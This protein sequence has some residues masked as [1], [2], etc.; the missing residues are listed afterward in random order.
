MSLLLVAQNRNMEPWKKAFLKEENDLDIEIWPDVQNPDQVQFAVAWRH[1]P[2][3]LTRFP[4]L[5]AVSSLGAGI[6]HILDDETL[7]KGLKIC[8]VVDPNL[9]DD[10]KEYMLGAVLNYRL[11]SYTYYQQ[12]WNGEWHPLPKKKANDFTIGIMGLGAIGLPVAKN[13]ARLGYRV[14]GWSNS[15]KDIK[16]VA[17]FSGKT[18]FDDFLKETD[19]LICLLPL[20][21]DT[22]GILNLNVF[23]KINHPGYLIN[24][25]RGAHLVEEDLIYALDKQWLSGALLD[26]FSEEPLPVNHPFWNRK[27]IIMT[28][29]VSA[30]TNPSSVATQIIENYKRTISGMP[31]VN[32]V[33]VKKK[34]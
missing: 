33:D 27:N 7:P 32:E 11:N 22:E 8:R 4:N 13:F 2:H 29:H 24:A 14:K 1:P 25:G 31:L 16:G 6:D 12:K 21:P 19:L 10:M 18:E 15:K 9:T 23:K 30:E 20:T 5:Q 3:S 26:V 17:I 28:P 34:Y